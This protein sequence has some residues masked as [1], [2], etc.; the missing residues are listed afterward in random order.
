MKFIS[1]IEY[2]IIS[3]S[4]SQY[5]F[6]KE[7][8]CHIVSMQ[9][10]EA[11][12][13]QDILL[14][15]GMAAAWACAGN[16]SF[17][18][19]RIGGWGER[20]AELDVLA[21]VF[22]VGLLFESVGVATGWIYGY[23]HYTSELGPKFLGL[24]PYLIPVAWFM[25]SYP[26]FVIA[27]RPVSSGWRRWQRVLAVAV[28]GG[29]VI[30]AWDVVMDP[31]M[32]SEGFWIR[33]KG[34]AYFGIPL[35]NFWGWWLTV[36]TTFALYLW[37][38]RKGTKAAEAEND[39]QALVSHLVTGLSITIISFLSGTG[40]LALIGFF[41]MMPWVVTAGLKLS[42]KSQPSLASLWLPIHL[43]LTRLQTVVRLN[44]Q[45]SLQMQKRF[46]PGSYSNSIF[47]PGSTGQRAA[48]QLV[49][50]V[51]HYTH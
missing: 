17:L 23:Y 45:A 1:L 10:K 22:V 26:F 19:E 11:C 21:L 6:I 7:D 51:Y 39:W 16:W 27:D 14:P 32:I 34:G 44:R 40:G 47:Y 5:Y 28:V 42:T 46:S 3:I 4:Q 20:E 48:L 50:A 30:T 24:V 25:M 38:F 37:L 29:L 35:Q 12:R 41:T 2:N 49:C 15:P 33:D 13:E 9:Q 8:E 36:F 31:I 43:I 18:P